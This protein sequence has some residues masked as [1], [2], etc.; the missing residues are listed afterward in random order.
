MKELLQN[1]Q[2]LYLFLSS[3]ATLYVGMGLFPIL[4]LYIARF[5]DSSSMAG[6]YLA[7][8]YVANALGPVTAGWLAGRVPRRALFVAAGLAGIPAIALMGLA[9]SFWQLTVLTSVVWFA[10]GV[11]LTLVPIFTNMQTD[12]SNRGKAF[13]LMALAAPLGALAGGATV[14]R[15]V[16]WQGYT[17]MFLALSLEWAIIPLIGLFLLKDKGREDAGREDAVREDAG[18]ADKRAT[19]S[20]GMAK[21]FNRS[22]YL[23]LGVI[24]LAAMA[25]GV[26]RMAASISMQVLDYGAEA[27]SS[28]NMISGLAAIPITLA[29]GSLSDRLGRKHFLTI[30]ILFTL[31]GSVMLINAAQLWQFWAAAILHLIS[32]S[33]NGSMG[34][35]L[36][37]EIVGREHQGRGL[38]WLNATTATAS[39]F[40]FAGGG[41]II[42]SMGLNAVFL[43]AAVLA[44]VAAAGLQGL[45]NVGR[46]QPTP[47]PTAQ[48]V[49]INRKMREVQCL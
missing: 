17:G 40:C 33:I 25:H 3:F 34:Q 2:I 6:V 45:R 12:P 29:I 14:G 43:G 22:Y 16:A 18:R 42:D 13:S 10:G 37:T 28:A 19:R 8:V 38:S 35:A 32:F 5:S 24:L 11:N 4:P 39:I 9:S 48:T 23:L 21:V 44:G 15:L 27:V 1:K 26:S 41:V 49:P 46:P 31:A 47:C 30:S 36:T 7:I 20:Q